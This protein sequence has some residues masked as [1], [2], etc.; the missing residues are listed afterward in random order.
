M[1]ELRVEVDLS[2]PPLHLYWLTKRLGQPAR[3]APANV[4]LCDTCQRADLVRPAPAPVA[5]DARG[6]VVR[7]FFGG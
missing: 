7:L 6:L 3:L 4:A 5:P 1:T 2:E